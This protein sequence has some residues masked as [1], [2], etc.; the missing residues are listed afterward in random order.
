MSKYIL[1]SVLGLCMAVPGYAQS[2]KKQ[3]GAP[4][5]AGA[6]GQQ[7]QRP[8]AQRPKAQRQQGQRQQGQRQQAQRPQGQRQQRG[9]RQQGGP[10]RTPPILRVAGALSAAL[11]R[12][13]GK[14][15]LAVKDLEEK[16][17]QNPDGI[18]NPAGKAALIK[19]LSDIKEAGYDE[20]KVEAIFAEADK[21]K[22]S[23]RQQGGRQPGRPG[24]ATRPGQ[25]G[26]PGQATRP[27]QP[28][29]PGQ[30][31]RTGQPGRS[32]QATRPG[33]PGRSGQATRPGQQGSRT[34]PRVFVALKGVFPEDPNNP[35][36]IDPAARD[37]GLPPSVILQ[38]LM[39]LDENK[40]GK[41]SP[42]ELLL[43][44]KP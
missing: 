9:Q 10:D 15:D 26:R 30:A 41:L 37:K 33:Q 18:S 11:A 5:Q 31:T 22:A 7:A 2:E 21:V 38:G 19:A 29:R 34:P 6:K 3:P 35:R 17:K 8:K 28:G 39:K 4:S 43:P 13:D 20:K 24:Q 23:A 27:G 32:G 12:N 14:I 36:Q 25:P 16:L 1:T 42:D 44:S 40:D